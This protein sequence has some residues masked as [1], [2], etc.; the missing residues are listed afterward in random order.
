MQIEA[1][2]EAWSAILLIA[3]ITFG[4]RIMG[5]LLM[6]SV[7]VSP[8]VARYLDVLSVCVI[9][10]LVASV[11]AQGDPRSAAAVGIAAIVMVAFRSAVWAMLGGMAIAAVW[12]LV[13]GQLL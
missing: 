2:W 7:D 1:D 13:G 4:S 8:L 10:A 9:A 12:T 11:I 3:G 5:S 6:S